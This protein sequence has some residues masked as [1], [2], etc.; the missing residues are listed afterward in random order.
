MTDLEKRL[1]LLKKQYHIVKELADILS[2]I[3][4]NHP[5]T[6]EMYVKSIHLGLALDILEGKQTSLSH[7]N[8]LKVLKENI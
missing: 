2:V 1:E 7:E 4:S 3:N 6:I 5:T 8:W